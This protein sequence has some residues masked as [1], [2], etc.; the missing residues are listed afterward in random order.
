MDTATDE[1]L[2][3]SPA[4]RGLAVLVAAGSVCPGGQE[5]KQHLGLLKHNMDTISPPI[6]S[7]IL[8][9]KIQ[10]EY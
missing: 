2:G 5:P 4:E 3:G 10:K 1:Q 7:A 6:P 9:S 8:G